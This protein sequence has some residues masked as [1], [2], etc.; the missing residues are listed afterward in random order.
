MPQWVSTLG[1]MKLGKAKRLFEDTEITV[2]PR[3]RNVRWWCGEEPKALQEKAPTL[4][5]DK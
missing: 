5:S 2:E 4:L 3:A 1:G